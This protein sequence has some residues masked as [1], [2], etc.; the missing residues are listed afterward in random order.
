M[1]GYRPAPGDST[2]FKALVQYARER[3]EHTQT[4]VPMLEAQLLL[5]RAIGK[6]REYLLT[7]PEKSPTKSQLRKFMGFVQRREKYEPIAYILEEKEFFSYTFRSD[8]RA[9]VPRPETEKIVEGALAMF[10]EGTKIS[11]LDI[12]AGSGVIC[13][14]LAKS[15]P[16]WRFTAID[17]S[18]DAL[19]LARENAAIHQVERRVT[20]INGDLF[21]P[22]RKKFNLIVSDP[23]Y[24]PTI[25]HD[26][27]PDITGHEPEVSLY[28]GAD[29]LDLIREIIAR[30]PGRLLPG[31]G[32]ILEVGHTHMAPVKKLIKAT[33]FFR[34]IEVIKDH[35]GTDRVI[36]A[37]G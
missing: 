27:R 11:A 8:N 17:I 1:T 24:V 26:L 12:G 21:P 14:S 36:C 34:T 20:F 29:G 15:R 6:S 35:Q 28:G 37:K 3:I 32:L 30:A 33:G 19:E 13:V 5:C 9:L 22:N 7:Y 18:D 10:A 16:E 23:P 4:N 25:G 31:G 2:S